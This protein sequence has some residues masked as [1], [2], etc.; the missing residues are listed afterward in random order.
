LSLVS[1]EKIDFTWIKAKDLFE[2]IKNNS[3]DTKNYL[4]EEITLFKPFLQTL[5][6]NTNFIEQTFRTKTNTID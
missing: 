3:L 5:K 1:Q 2:A 6:N 4:G